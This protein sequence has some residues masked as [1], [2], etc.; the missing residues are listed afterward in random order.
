MKLKEMRI[1]NFRSFKDETIR[2]DD[3]TCFVGANGSG[4][5]GVLMAL[6][7]F[8]RESASTQTDVLVLGEEDFHH[9]NTRKPV[10]IILTFEELT[11]E[12]KKDFQHYYRQEKLI[13]FAIAHWEE[14]TR[15]AP[16]KQCGSRL[17]MEEFAPFFEAVERKEKVEQLKEIYKKI[18]QQVDG[19]P[20]IFTKA[21]MT[22]ALRNYEES[23]SEKCKLIDDSS[24]LYGWTRGQNRLAKYIQWVYV[25][26]I[27]DPSAEQEEASKT[28]LGRLLARTVRTRLDFSE[29]IESVR[30][31]VVQ[32]Y[33]EMLESRNDAL[34]GLKLSMEK[35]LQEYAGGHARLKLEWH[36]DDKQSIKI[37]DPTAWAHIGDGPFIGEVARSG[38]G[39][40]RAFLVTLMHELACNEAQGGPKLLLGFEEPELYQHPP[41]AMR[42]A[43]VLEKLSSPG[44][45]SQ[46]IVTTHSPYF[47]SSK[48][49]ENVRVVRKWDS[50]MTKIAAATF[51]DLENCISKALNEKPR[52]PTSLM[53]RL[54]QILLPSQNELFFTSVAV[55]VE[56]QEDVA[57]ISTQLGLSQQLREFRE[58]GCHFI[59]SG[60]KTNMSRLVAIALKLQIPFFLVFDADGDETRTDERTKH[61]RDNSCLMRLCGFKQFNAF[62][63]EVFWADS[64]VVWPQ[65]ICQ[66][67]VGDIGC[68]LWNTA[69]NSARVK[70]GLTEGIRGKN[71]MLVAYTLE[72][73][74][75]E[76]KQSPL[77]IKLCAQILRWAATVRVRG[78]EER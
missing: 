7:V 35:R 62:P 1:E 20:S 47:I 37:N 75:E 63:G 65:N 31:D 23:H 58:L 11:E 9:R 30:A 24:E 51:I 21:G 77:L 53:A 55:L 40:Q 71:S 69:Q 74:K 34:N 17:V 15:T 44:G 10:K 14:K 49:F 25:P 26:A 38:H 68:Q 72:Q 60:G 28:A 19:L 32:K 78:F 64:L 6:N 27:K 33:R 59:I 4:K 16:V 13:L 70:Y 56:G 36:Y 5:S 45:N 29:E 41:Q 43:D 76:E 52:S 73:L 39:L 61:E 67:V 48:G 3:Y 54:G 66:S 46:V 18:C 8:F 2:F 42:L 50:G 57:F 12:A 22:D